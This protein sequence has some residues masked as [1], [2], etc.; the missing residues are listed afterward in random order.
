MTEISPDRFRGLFGSFTNVFLNVS[1]LL[2]EVFALPELLGTDANW[3]YLLGLGVIPAALQ[4]ALCPFFPETPKFLLLKR[5]DEKAAATALRY[6]QGKNVDTVKIFAEFQ[7]ET[8]LERKEVGLFTALAQTHLRYPIGLGVVASVAQNISGI[9]IITA[10]ST[11][12]FVGVGAT[13]NTAQLS[14]IAMGVLSVLATF[15]SGVL[16]ERFGRRP[17][18]IWGNFA[19]FCCLLGFVVVSEIQAVWEYEWLSYLGISLILLFVIIYN[20]GPGPIPW[21]VRL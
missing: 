4:I 5:G 13:D 3:P 19:V 21:S 6:F 18:L 17:M 14:T 8:E 2:S 12:L 15:F 16:I 9:A 10:F 1:V 7:A 20:L 11:N